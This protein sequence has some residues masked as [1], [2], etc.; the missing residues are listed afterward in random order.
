M[1][2]EKIILVVFWGFVTFIFLMNIWGGWAEQFYK[3]F[4]ENSSAWYWLRVFNL[5]INEK[6]C[7]RFL[8]GTSWFG[9]FMISILSLIILV[10]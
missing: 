6:N 10:I 5:T 8:K 4:G 9:I 1:E 7:V 3:K 2:I